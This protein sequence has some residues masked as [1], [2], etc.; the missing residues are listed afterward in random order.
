MITCFGGFIIHS[1]M[2]SGVEF[3]R[4]VPAIKFLVDETLT[5]NRFQI[6]S[7]LRRRCWLKRSP[8][9]SVLAPVPVEPFLS[10]DLSQSPCSVCSRHDEPSTLAHFSSHFSLDLQFPQRTSLFQQPR[11]CVSDMLPF[12]PAP[13]DENLEVL[14]FLLPVLVPT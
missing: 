6:Q 14:L 2:R 11:P 12:S 5:A 10:A 7:Q 1:C 8:I 9:R 4:G 13:H 3:P